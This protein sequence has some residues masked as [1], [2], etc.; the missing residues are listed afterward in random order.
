MEIILRGADALVR[1]TE[2]GY[3]VLGEVVLTGHKHS[4]I[5]ESKVEITICL[6]DREIS[7]MAG[8][9]KAAIRALEETAD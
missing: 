6:K 3:E 1:T 5:Y 9:L 7:V 2:A 4:N 8:E